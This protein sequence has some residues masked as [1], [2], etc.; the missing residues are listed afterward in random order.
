VPQGVGALFRGVLPRTI[1]LAP[2][3]ALVYACY[4]EFKRLIIKFKADKAAA[5]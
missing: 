2:L 5:A 3:A 4:E 1:Y